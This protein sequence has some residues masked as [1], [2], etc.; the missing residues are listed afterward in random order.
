MTEDTVEKRSKWEINKK[1]IKENT[2]WI[3]GES[4]WSADDRPMF[5]KARGIISY[6]SF[7]HYVE[8]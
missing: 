3:V 1:N 5:L 2:L 8:F 6:L 4:H 7:H